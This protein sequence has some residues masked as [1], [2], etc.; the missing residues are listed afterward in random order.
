[1]N[2]RARG[3][4]LIEIMVAMVIGLIVSLGIVQVFIASKG[5]YQTQNASA[6]MQEDARFI[7]SKLIQEIRMT[8]MYGCLKFDEPNVAP[9]IR[10][11]DAFSNPILWDN[12]AKTLT[13]VTADVGNAGTAPTWTV[14][15]DCKSTSRLFIGSRAPGTGQTALPLRSIVYT[16]V[17]SDLRMKVGN[18]NDDPQTILSNVVRLVVSFGIT[19]NPMSYV[20]TLAT[21]SAAD[22][23]RS[24]R[25]T[26]ELS[27][28]TGRV[29]R[30]TYNAVAAIRNRF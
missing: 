10:Q 19:G 27:D 24:V 23:I 16:L 15:T 12:A 17:G 22:D 29:R 1:M 20:S 9:A 8:G 5:T 28:P 14:I 6:R 18:G 25:L 21:N 2:A 11:P 13:L 4:G 30:Q 7:L 3:F 26:L